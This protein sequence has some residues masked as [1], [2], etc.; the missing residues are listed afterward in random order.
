[1]CRQS[2]AHMIRMRFDAPSDILLDWL[3]VV[4]TSTTTPPKDPR[5]Y[6]TLTFGLSND[7][8]EYHALMMGLTTPHSGTHFQEEE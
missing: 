7:N 4:T 2:A 5:A 6:S 8:V 1:M 3:D